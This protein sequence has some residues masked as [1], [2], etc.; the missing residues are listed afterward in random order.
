LKEADMKRGLTVAL[1]LA[2]CAFATHSAAE[3]KTERRYILLNPDSKLPFSNGVL[4]GYTLY[5]AGSVG[6]D[7]KTGRPPAELEEEA[8]L[9][10]DGVRNTLVKAGMTMEDLVAVEVY[11][12]DVANY[13]KFNDVYRTYFQHEFP[14]RAFLGSGPLL[15]G[16]RFEVKGIAVKR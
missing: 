13:A 15:F 7:P 10:L 9:A 8:R 14:A 4:V 1:I 16:A 3:N 12:S 11:C 6:L 2:I 5:V